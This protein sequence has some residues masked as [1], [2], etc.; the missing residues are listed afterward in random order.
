MRECQSQ[1][2]YLH[3]LVTTPAMF[4]H[5]IYF[6]CVPTYFQTVDM[7]FSRHSQKHGKKY[8]YRKHFCLWLFL[9]IY[10]VAV[11]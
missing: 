9:Q 2:T 8:V 5:C 10:N 7:V 6:A 3:L 1:R 4:K 11:N